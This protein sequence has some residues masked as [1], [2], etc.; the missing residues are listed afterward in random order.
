MPQARAQR[1]RRETQRTVLY[2]DPVTPRAGAPVTVF[3]NPDA[4][5]LRGRPEVWLRGCWNRCAEST[6]GKCT[7][8]TGGM[9]RWDGRLHPVETRSCL[10]PTIGLGQLASCC[11]A[12]SPFQRL[13][14]AV[15]SAG[16]RIQSATCRDAC[17]PP[18]PLAT[19]PS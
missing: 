9:M 16:G 10:V 13:D 19:S 15:C 3:Y 6:V 18:T 8:G 4:T 2:T 11:G 14:H 1:R 17:S 7:A 12:V 5:V